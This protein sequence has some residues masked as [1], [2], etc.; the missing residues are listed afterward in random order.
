MSAYHVSLMHLRSVLLLSLFLISNFLFFSLTLYFF[1]PS[2]SC[3]T[4]L[5]S[6]VVKPTNI[7]FAIS[8]LHTN[9]II[10]LLYIYAGYFQQIE[11]ASK[12]LCY[13]CSALLQPNSTC[14]IGGVEET[15]ECSDDCFVS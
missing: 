10:C 11:C 7:I 15:E 9:V 2:M 8:Y 14:L 5:V 1:L 12:F 13:K 4:S 6:R 3:P